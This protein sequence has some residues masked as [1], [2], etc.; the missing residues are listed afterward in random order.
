MRILFVILSLFPLALDAK[1]V[2]VDVAI[3]LA[4]DRSRSMDAEEILLQR[5]GYIEALNSAIV[6]KA[7]ADGDLG[8]IAMTYVEWSN[9]ED[10]QVIV[11]W[12]L[13]DGSTAAHEFSTQIKRSIIVSHQ[14]TS[15]SNSLAFSATL[16]E[17]SPFLAQ[18]RVIDI[19]GDG[20]NNSGGPVLAARDAVLARGITINGLPLMINGKVD[21]NT[22]PDLDKYFEYCVIGGL[23]SF[24]LPVFGW[25]QFPQSIQEKLAIEI[26]GITPET[27]IETFFN[28]GSYNCRIGQT[29]LPRIGR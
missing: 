3:V 9:A 22:L 6:L 26:A 11:P 14:K 24:V 15:I 19:S 28:A 20:P 8:R 17:H 5:S 21:Q 2:E 16:F 13:I 29:R 25:E 1:S 18:R 23:G 27:Q 4:V 12:T 10:Q 7:I